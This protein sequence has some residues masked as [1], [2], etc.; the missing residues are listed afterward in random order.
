MYFRKIGKFGK[1]VLMGSST[2][3]Q[4]VMEYLTGANAA[5]RPRIDGGIL[6]APVSDREAIIMSMKPD[7]YRSSK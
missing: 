1:I 7:D 5:K 3:C 4:D 2:G 6:Q